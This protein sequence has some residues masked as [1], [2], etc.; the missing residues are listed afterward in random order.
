[1]LDL[2]PGLMIWTI[3]SFLILLFILKKAAWTPIVKALEER[4]KGIKDD[5]ESARSARE[6]AEKSMDDYR[7]KLAEAQTE[8]QKVVEKARHDAERVGEELKAKY[9]A[10]AE[11]QLEKARKQ[12]EL[13][14]QAAINEIRGEIATLAITAAEKIITKNLNSEDNRRLVM[15]GLKESEN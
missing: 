2:Y 4:E 11:S 10:D 9:K 12:I 8:A 3:V 1:M 15:E 14:K 7:K 5:I 6:E 13:E